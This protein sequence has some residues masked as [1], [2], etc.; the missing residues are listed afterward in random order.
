MNLRKYHSCGI[1]NACG[2]DNVSAYYKSLVIIYE[3]KV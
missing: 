3:C 1:D 2:V